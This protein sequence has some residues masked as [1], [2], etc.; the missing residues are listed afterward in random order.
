MTGTV[1]NT[2]KTEVSMMGKRLG[3]VTLKI[4]LWPG[5]E[6]IACCFSFLCHDKAWSTDLYIPLPCGHCRVFLS[7]FF[8][9]V[10]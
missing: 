7:Y 10:E 6:G 2:E 8:C 9:D 4:P 5:L 3:Y 1:P